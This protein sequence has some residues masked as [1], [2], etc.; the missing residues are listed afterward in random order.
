[1]LAGCGAPPDRPNGCIAYQPA[2][3]LYATLGRVCAT[4]LNGEW[5]VSVKHA[6]IALAETG[7]IKDPDYDLVFFRRKAEAPLWRDAVEDEPVEAEGNPSGLLD[8]LTALPLPTRETRSG[9]VMQAAW[10]YC[11]SEDTRGRC[12][13]AILFGA[14]VEHGYSGGPLIG[15][16]DGAIIGMVVARYEKGPLVGQAVALPT[17]LI[18]SEFQRLVVERKEPLPEPQLRLPHGGG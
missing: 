14:E 9:F 18:Q 4:Q 2:I 13:D 8:V 1:M 12:T 7:V 10:R 6:G 17:A 15:I 16:S 5:A 11:G 3:P